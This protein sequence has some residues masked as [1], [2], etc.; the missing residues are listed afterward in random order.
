MEKM[1]WIE[2]TVESTQASSFLTN[3]RTNMAGFVDP[4]E[5]VTRRNAFSTFPRAR[6]G[7]EL[8]FEAKSGRLKH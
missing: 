7:G 4:H 6:N 5:V 2:D 1:L 8:E 3:S